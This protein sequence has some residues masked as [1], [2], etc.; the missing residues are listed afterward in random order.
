[1]RENSKVKT[2]KLEDKF[3]NLLNFLGLEKNIDYERNYLVSNIKTFF[4]FRLINSN[5]LIEVD[6]DFYHCN[7]DTIFKE[8]SHEIQFKN[9]Y[10]D[11]RKNIWAKNHNISLIRFWE[12][13]INERPEWVINELRKIIK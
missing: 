5:M 3:E 7:P 11:K 9:L 8:P 12:T 4:D 1:M 10:N 13:D 6:G 2:S